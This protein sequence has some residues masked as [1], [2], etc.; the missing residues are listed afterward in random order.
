VVPNGT[1]FAGGVAA[2]IKA[3]L[4]D[5]FNLHTVVRLPN[6]VFAPYTTIPVNVLFFD[7][8]GPTTQTWFYEHPAPHGR[9]AYTKMKPLK[10]EE[11]GPLLS[12]W[13]AREENER[14]W[15]VSADELVAREYNL[16]VKNP[17]ARPAYDEIAPD[18]LTRQLSGTSTRLTAVLAQITGLLEEAAK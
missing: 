18:E 15:R 8:S 4:L 3:D 12:W 1:L 7:R 9:R 6:G 2:R 5:G 14:S 11:F 13:E 16:D 17:N 10:F